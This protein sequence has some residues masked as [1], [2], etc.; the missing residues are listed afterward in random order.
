LNCLK[1]KC[2]SKIQTPITEFSFHFMAHRKLALA[3]LN[4][5]TNRLELL[6]LNITLNYWRSFELTMAHAWS[7]MIH[8]L[9]YFLL[10]HVEFTKPFGA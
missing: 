6:M 1:Q 10:G 7:H 3:K 5:S 8:I 2:C 9:T 4:T